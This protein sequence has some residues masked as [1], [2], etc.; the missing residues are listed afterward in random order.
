MWRCPGNHRPKPTKNTKNIKRKE[1][2]YN[3]KENY[4]ATREDIKR[5]G[6]ING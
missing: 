1:S 6:R 4:Q 2:K 3:N 5:R